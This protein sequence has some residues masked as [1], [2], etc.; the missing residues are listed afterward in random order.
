[1]C[2]I[3]VA[4]NQKNAPVA[5][6]LIKGMNDRIVH[7]GPDNE[8]VF[9]VENLAFGH[10]RLSILDLSAAGHQPM[11][12]GD[13]W[14]TYNGEVYNYLEL[15]EELVSLGHT[16]KTQTDT[17]VILAAYAEWGKAAFDKF[18]GMWAFAIYDCKKNKVIFCRDHFG[19]KPLC[20]TYAGGY[21]LAGSEIK[22]FL[23]APEFNPILNKDVA[24]NFLVHGWLN[25]SSE[26][27]FVGVNELKPGHFLEY[28]LNDNS[29]TIVE[30]YNLSNVCKQIE[31]T[32]EIAAAKIRALLT[33][34]IKIRMRSDVKVGSCLS[35]GIDSSS[36]VSLINSNQLANQ[37]FA[38]ITS[39]YSNPQYDEQK[40]SDTISEKTGFNA[41]KVYPN[42]DD[43]WDL[44]ELDKI[45][46]HQDQPIASASHYSEF[47]VFQKAKEAGLIVMQDG[48]GADEY[49][50]GYGEFYITRIM[51]LFKS[52]QPIAAFRLMRDKAIH[53][54][55]S[56]IEEIKMF[57]RT[58]FV[59]KAIDLIKRI[60]RKNSY[61]WFTPKWASFA[62]KKCMQFKKTTIRELSI[63]E[64]NKISIPYQLHSEDRNSMLFSI[65]SRLPFLDPRLV[66]YA[67]GLPSSYKIK[68]GYTKAVL[69]DAIQELPEI[70][71]YRKD[72]MGF[73]APDIPWMR[74]NQEKVRNE[75]NN[76]VETTDIFSLGLVE[77]FD[78]FIK[79]EIG[80]EP[81]FFRALTF[82]RFCDLF[83][84][85]KI[86]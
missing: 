74:D 48:Q 51:E 38:T 24:V 78:K 85:E 60:L 46:Y 42:L 72:K 56:I 35:G 55:V 53:K 21:F 79:G 34:S 4:I 3:S 39:C 9:L 52:M 63:L 26:T 58:V 32:Y 18:N 50:C 15:K 82:K 65:E 57:I 22:Q 2:G 20:Y 81:I 36:I 13:L 23:D 43:L 30:W 8:G 70:I 86:L 75:L 66:Q 54:N 31:D 12:R 41:I 47:K 19:I 77:R 45:I 25:Y 83:K 14:I 49:L 17:E 33:D 37:D 67:I 28:N 6:A 27:F 84:M 1:M 40:F 61:P 64:I 44:G 7:R 10:R 80:Y 71:K 11:S 29:I 16:F 69:R 68:N 5:P 59:F 62:K 76:L 73:V